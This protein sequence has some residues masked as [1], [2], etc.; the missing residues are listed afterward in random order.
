MSRYVFSDLHGQYDLWKQIKEYMKPEDTAYCL[1]DCTDRGLDGLSILY[2][3][4]NDERITLLKGNHEDMMAICVPEFI[5]GHFEN[6]T[7]WWQ[8]GGGPTWDKIELAPYEEKLRLVRKI[9]ALPK[10]IELDNKKGEHIILSHAGTNPGWTERDWESLFGIKDPY[11]WNRKHIKY[12]W[13]K[14]G[15]DNTYIIHGHTP[16]CANPTLLKNIIPSKNKY[17]ISQY[18]DGHKI[19]LD[20]GC[21]ITG[22]AALFD[23]D[24]FE[25]VYFY[26]KDKSIPE[27]V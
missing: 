9:N 1:G 21:F 27:E 17:G 12:D 15:Y 25:V 24:T 23:I 16:T 4:L 7:W 22:V 8:N 13:P 5:D 11:I 10:V 19:C 14:E 3:V 26:A 6:W 18:A 2:E 20:T